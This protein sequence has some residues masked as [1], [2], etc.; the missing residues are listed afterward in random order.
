MRKGVYNKNSNG[1]I[2]SDETVL[3][4]AGVEGYDFILVKTH[5]TI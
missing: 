1:E 3:S 4:G 2:I 5:R